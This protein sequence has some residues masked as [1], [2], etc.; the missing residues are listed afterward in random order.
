MEDDG[1]QPFGNLICLINTRLTFPYDVVVAVV[2]VIDIAIDVVAAVVVTFK[3][4]LI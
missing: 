4:Q 2:V 1:D 3:L